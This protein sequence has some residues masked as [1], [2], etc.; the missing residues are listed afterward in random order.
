MTRW[1]LARTGMTDA[2]AQLDGEQAAVE[3]YEWRPFAP[4][5]DSRGGVH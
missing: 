2:E 1:C 5:L 3:Q 4:L